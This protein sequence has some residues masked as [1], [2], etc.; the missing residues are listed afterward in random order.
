MMDSAHSAPSADDLELGEW[1]HQQIAKAFLVKRSEWV[2]GIAARLQSTRPATERLD[3]TVV[4]L[5]EMTAFTAPGRYIYVTGRLMEYCPGEASLAFTLAHEVAHHDLGHLQYFPRWVRDVADHW[6]T[7]IIFLLVH[8]VQRF[9]YSPERECAADRHALD[10]CIRAGYD[11]QDCLH[12]FTQLEDRLLDLGD[13]AGVYG[14]SDSDEELVR[15]ASFMTKL[16]IWVG[17]RA[18]GYMPVRDRRR[19]LEAYIVERGRGGASA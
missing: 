15:D 2:D 11:P 8:G 4:W 7:E 14:P 10:L 6:T 9:L 16:Q 5:S 3:V 1:F 13:F 18:R 19:A 12:L 17:Q